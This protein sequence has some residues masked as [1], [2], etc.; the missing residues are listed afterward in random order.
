MWTGMTSEVEDYCRSCA[1]C[2]VSKSTNAMPAGKLV[3]MPIP[4]RVWDS[5]GVDFTGPLPVTA[6]GNNSIMAHR[7]SLQQDDQAEGV[8]DDHYRHRVGPSCCWTRC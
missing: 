2:A 1:V 6:S 7:G 5:V 3:P 4:E 8:Q